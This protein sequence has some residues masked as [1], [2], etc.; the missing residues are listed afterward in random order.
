MPDD[1][2]DAQA[3][4][5][6]AQARRRRQKLGPSLTTTPELLAAMAEVGPA[7]LVT[8]EALVRDACGQFGVDL[9]RATK[10]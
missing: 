8:A 5:N 10:G 3:A 7:D 4:L 2:A 1:A 9:L 6:A